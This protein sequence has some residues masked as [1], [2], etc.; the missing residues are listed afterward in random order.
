MYGDWF[1][2]ANDIFNACLKTMKENGA[3]EFKD[4]EGI[5]EEDIKS[6]FSTLT[7]DQISKISPLQSFLWIDDV[8]V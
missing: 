3:G 2:D 8:H 6:L 7:M 5:S 4:K 1:K